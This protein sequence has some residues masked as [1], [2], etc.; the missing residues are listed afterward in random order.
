MRKIKIDSGLYVKA[1][2]RASEL[3][4]SSV[5]EYITHLLECNLD[6]PVNLKSDDT[7]KKRLKGLGYF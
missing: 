7:I 1:M 5:G 6:M 4:Y 3:N 2:R